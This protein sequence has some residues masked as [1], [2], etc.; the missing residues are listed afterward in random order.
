M[1]THQSVN[2]RHGYANL[3]FGD[4]DS[5]LAYERECEAARAAQPYK[6]AVAPRQEVTTHD[7]RKLRAGEEVT[8]DCFRAVQRVRQP[9]H[10]NAPDT[11]PHCR[12]LELAVARGAVPERY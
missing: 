8:L 11:L 3:G 6:Y 2:L 10:A 5:R 7:G 1:P 12:Q 4:D 9:G